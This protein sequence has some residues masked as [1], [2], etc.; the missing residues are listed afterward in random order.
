MDAFILVG[1]RVINTGQITDVH[2][3]A[4]SGQEEGNL[5]IYLSAESKDSGA[6]HITLHGSEGK[7]VW[8]Y[9]G[10]KAAKVI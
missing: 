5:S 4:G 2:W 3:A 6:R 9:L 1:D 10:S 8:E 7:A